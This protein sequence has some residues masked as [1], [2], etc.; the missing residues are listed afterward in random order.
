MEK[1]YFFFPFIFF[2]ITP[3]SFQI[4]TENLVYLDYL[5]GVF[6]RSIAGGT[7]PRDTSTVAGRPHAVASA[8]RSEQPA[9]GPIAAEVCLAFLSRVVGTNL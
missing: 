3:E 4:A 6:N 8:V 1:G 5:D 2:T 9:P 7:P